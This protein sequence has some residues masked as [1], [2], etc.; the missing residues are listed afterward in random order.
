MSFGLG[1]GPAAALLMTLPSTSFP[2]LLL[3]KRVFPRKVL[4]FVGVGVAVIGIVSG[5]LGMFIL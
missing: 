5:L 1:A 4:V 3:V 2:S